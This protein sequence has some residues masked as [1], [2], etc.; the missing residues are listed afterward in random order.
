MGVV[1]WS[2]FGL[3]RRMEGGDMRRHNLCVIIRRREDRRPN[4]LGLRRL[5][6]KVGAATKANEYPSRMEE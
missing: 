1:G 3:S 5:L 6:I 2:Y 4:L